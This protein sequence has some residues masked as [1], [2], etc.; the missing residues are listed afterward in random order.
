M[1]CTFIVAG[2]IADT[3]S[4]LVAQLLAYPFGRF[5]ARFV[6]Q[7]RIWNLSINPGPF[8]IKEHV[9]SLFPVPLHHH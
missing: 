8:T 1:S 9:G 2:P 3:L 5:W 6:P 4:Q 7:A